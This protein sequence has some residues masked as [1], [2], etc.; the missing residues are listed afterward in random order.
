MNLQVVSM[1]GPEEYAGKNAK[2]KEAH[3]TGKRFFGVKVFKD[4]M[5]EANIVSIS[6]KENDM[7][8]KGS[9]NEE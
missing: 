8:E 2:G 7:S 9:D 6:D 3:I 1:Y 5:N 4:L